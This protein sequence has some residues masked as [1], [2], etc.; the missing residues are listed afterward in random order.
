M[1]TYRELFRTPE[2]LP[3]FTTVSVQVAAQTAAGLALGTLVYAATGS[4]LLSALA[5]FGPS[6]AQVAGA[7]TLLSAAD[8]LPPRATLTG[9]ALLFALGTG[10]Q[11][12][13]GLPLWAAFAVLL[14]LGVASSLGGGVRYGLLNEILPQRGFLL[15]RSVLNMAVGTMQIL[16]FAVGGVLVTALSARGTLLVGAALYVVAAALARFGL[17]ARPPR[18]DPPEVRPARHGEGDQRKVRAEDLAAQPEGREPLVHGAGVPPEGAVRHGEHPDGAVPRIGHRPVD[19]CTPSAS[20]LNRTV[21][22]SATPSWRKGTLSTRAVSA[23][24]RVAHNPS[25][26]YGS[27][28]SRGTKRN[29]TLIC[30]PTSRGGRSSR[31]GRCGP[32]GELM[33]PWSPLRRTPARPAPAAAHR[34][35][36]RSGHQPLKPAGAPNW[37]RNRSIALSMAPVVA[38]RPLPR[39]TSRTPLDAYRPTGETSP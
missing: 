15:G 13:P 2:F 31:G 20:V 7:L 33:A 8:R 18:A 25:V 39:D 10:V 38:I 34:H 19:Q 36:S 11:A 35:A 27:Q 37:R 24:S 4:P 14:G 26:S 6:L 22:P 29:Q 17:T 3:F 16:G 12:V 23:L 1:R 30:R 32:A 28:S 9:L 5:M 21:S